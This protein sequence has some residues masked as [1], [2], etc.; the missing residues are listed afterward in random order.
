[1]SIEEWFQRQSRKKLLVAG[2]LTGSFV[3]AVLGASSL[4]YIH[5]TTASSSPVTHQRFV[6]TCTVSSDRLAGSLVVALG[7]ADPTHALRLLQA[8]G[9][10]LPLFT[11]LLRF[12]TDSSAEVSSRANGLLFIGIVGLVVGG[13]VAAFSGI[14]T[15]TAVILKIALSFVVVTFLIIAWVASRMFTEMLDS[16]ER[17]ATSEL[18]RQ[19]GVVGVKFTETVDEERQAN[20]GVEANP[21]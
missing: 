6:N 18:Q 16:I 13:V 12:T 19:V 10:L 20:D 4:C 21:D 2:V 7:T 9:I 5:L 1:M 15:S 17:E 8:I 11:G 14:F 3:G